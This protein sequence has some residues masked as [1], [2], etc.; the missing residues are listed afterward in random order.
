M[1]KKSVPDTASFALLALAAVLAPTIGGLTD[2]PPY[3]LI[4][5]LA[6]L[7]ILI[8]TVA[9]LQKRAGSKN[10]A[11]SLPYGVVWGIL[12]VLMIVSCL[13][14][15]SAYPGIREILLFAS[16]LAGFWVATKLG[17][18]GRFR[19]ALL[20]VVSLTAFAV[21]LF[22]IRDFAINSG[23]GSSFWQALMHPTD[24]NRLFGTFANPNFFSGFIVL[25]LPVTL[26]Y[27][28]TQRGTAAVVAFV[29]FGVE[30]ACLLLTAAKFGIVAGVVGMVVFVGLALWRGGW[31][32]VNRRAVVTAAIV[33]V[34]VLVVFSASLRTRVGEAQS[35]GAQAHSTT[36][37]IYTWKATVGMIKANP[38]LGTGPGT[39]ETAYPRYTIAGTTK[40]AHQ[41]YLQFAA[42]NGVP[43]LIVFLAV[44]AMCVVRPAFL[45]DAEQI[46]T[47]TPQPVKKG[48]QPQPDKF[49]FIDQLVT[50]QSWPVLSAGIAGGLAA[51]MA[52]NLVDSDWY[53]LG[54]WL[55]FWILAG[56]LLSG[57]KIA[58]S[59]PKIAPRVAWAA[60]FL[61]L[62]VVA[63]TQYGAD[64]TAPSP[65][66]LAYA[67]STGNVS[68][69]TESYRA[70]S[71]LSPLNPEDHRELGKLLSVSDPSESDREFAE[72]IR[73]AP[74]DGQNYFAQGMMLLRT[75]K[76]QEAIESLR[77]AQR[78][79]PKSTQIIYTL[80]EAYQKQ[81]R[82]IE[83]EQ[84][85][86]DLLA[87]ENTPYE[88]LK[89]VPEMVDVRYAFAHSY[90]AKKA[91]AAGNP[92]ESIKE[93]EPAISR[94]ESWRSE[95]K[96]LQ[97]ARATGS[98][99]QDEE[100]DRLQLLIDSYKLIAK[101]YRQVGETGKASLAEG[102]AG[103]D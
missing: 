4:E 27:C 1:F 8:L 66:Q 60:A 93:L 98:L 62:A 78:Y 94:L 17:M 86:R 74:K 82:T 65:E 56:V 75:G 22:A 47:P 80:A 44:L 6:L 54:I 89:G 103:G 19:A 20:M 29:A 79:A 87:T 90:F 45:P 23:G 43:A 35:G 18:D 52:R 73:L 28:V 63:A 83:Y 39:F 33:G 2:S 57:K 96:Y 5:L 92:H 100:R 11:L 70:A 91:M 76:L 15:E 58:T 53:I 59:S 72:A 7:G 46:P 67:Y 31:K 42:E 64:Y 84:A 9:S 14:G 3:P 21:C 32:I 95:T 38:I 81:G 13:L 97:I 77:Q 51:S 25:V 40:H 48:K 12:F 26:A 71:K 101:A 16:G 37:R 30:L 69:L 55:P 10:G 36:F 41:A 99:S 34:L 102:K 68:S 49:A 50:P 88:Q 61:A 24:E 85:L